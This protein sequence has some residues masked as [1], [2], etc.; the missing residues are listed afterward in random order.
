MTE[1]TKDIQTLTQQASSSP[2]LQTN[3]GSLGSDL[4]N[5]ASFGLGLYRKNKAATELATAAG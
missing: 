1:F 3:T 4:I 2:Q 5:A